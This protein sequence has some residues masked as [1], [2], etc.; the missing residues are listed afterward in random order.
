MDAMVECRMIAESS[1]ALVSMFF[2]CNLD[3]SMLASVVFFS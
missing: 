3:Q 2:G 1:H